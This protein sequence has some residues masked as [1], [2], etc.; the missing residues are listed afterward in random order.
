MKD[1]CKGM[2]RDISTRCELPAGHDELHYAKRCGQWIDAD[3]SGPVWRAPGMRICA[4]C[5]EDVVDAVDSLT[6]RTYPRH[7]RAYGH[8]HAVI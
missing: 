1:R 8:D 7:V 6:G 4:L 3:S 2:R 5:G